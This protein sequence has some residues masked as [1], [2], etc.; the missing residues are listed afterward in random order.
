MRQAG[1]GSPCLP[2]EIR[3]VRHKGMKMR[4]ISGPVLVLFAT[5]AVLAQPQDSR[6][7]YVAASVKPNTSG[8]ENTSSN[9]S[10]GQ[11]V[12]TN[13]TLKRLIERAYNLKPFQLS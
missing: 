3:E 10:K 7:A 11:I 9:G 2:T 12:F 4:A 1:S 6:P 13:Q 8:S 5:G